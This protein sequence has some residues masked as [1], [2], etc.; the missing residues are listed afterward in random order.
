MKELWSRTFELFRSHMALWIPTSIAGILIL[1]FDNL[2]KAA[3]G[4]LFGL[5]ATQHSV[6]GGEA[7]LADLAQGQHRTMMLMYPLG[8]FKNFLEICFFVV[9]LIATKNLVQMILEEQKP[10]VIA[11]VREGLPWSREILLFS[12]K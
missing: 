6:L 11:A 7:P 9:A 2:E 3:V 5:F 10:D 8:F 12:I 1:I 4:W